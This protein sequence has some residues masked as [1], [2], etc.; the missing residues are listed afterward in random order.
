M[1]R[2]LV[3]VR[4]LRPH[5]TTEGLKQ[6]G[7]EYD[8]SKADAEQLECAGVVSIASAKAPSKRA[9]AS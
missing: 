2:D 5:D 7:D 4:T 1:S 9:K 8:R 3:K 6:P